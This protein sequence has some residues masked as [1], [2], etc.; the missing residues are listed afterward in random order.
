MMS[1]DGESRSQTYPDIKKEQDHLKDDK[2]N[3]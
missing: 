1:N 3:S 2:D